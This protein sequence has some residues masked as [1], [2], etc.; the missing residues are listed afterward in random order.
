MNTLLYVGLGL[1]IALMVGVAVWSGSPKRQKKNKGL[2]SILVTGLIIGTMIG[3][4]STVGTAQLAYNYGMEAWWYTLGSGIAALILGIFYTR[5]YRENGSP[6][7]LGMVRDEYGPKVGRVATVMNILGTMINLLAQLFAGSAVVLVVLPMLGTLPTI[8]ITAVLMLLY[9]VFGATKGAGI[10]GVLK[11]FLLYAAMLTTGIIAFVKIGGIGNVFAAFSDFSAETGRNYLNLFNQGFG[12]DFGSLIS[13][14]LGILSTETYAQA[15]IKACDEKN[16]R[17]GAIIAALMCP[18]IGILGIL[19]GLYMRTV[20]DP[21]TFPVK[22]ALTSFILEY[23]GLPT[24]IAGFLLGALLL[25]SVG[26]GAGLSLGVATM[27]NREFVKTKK[28]S[29]EWILRIIIAV[30]L[31][32]ATVLCCTP[33]SDTIISFSFLSMGLRA[34]TTFA[35]LTFLFFGK[36]KIKSGYAVASICCGTLITFVLGTLNL[37]KVIKLPMDAVIPGVTVGLM[38]MLIGYLKGKKKEML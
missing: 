17:R 1:A 19:V 15:I 30:V 25:V 21:A 4:S 36:R 24:I 8:I 28:I 23:S 29:E 26:S 33:I 11:C 27:I 5:K 3:G 6:T 20:T 31:I 38:I 37:Y 34:C 9:V 10:V 2:P 22:T 7:L 16:A 18:P 35:P 32:V 13:V 12:K 14:V